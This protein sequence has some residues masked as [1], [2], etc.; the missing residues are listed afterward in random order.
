MKEK[1]NMNNPGIAL[2][3]RPRMDSTPV[4]G[5]IPWHMIA[6]RRM[7]L[8]LHDWEICTYLEMMT[9]M[10]AYPHL[11]KK[12]NILHVKEELRCVMLCY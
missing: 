12:V 1:Q 8:F 5:N 9:K 7:S 6:E 2:Q 10:F 11:I 4:I 3:G